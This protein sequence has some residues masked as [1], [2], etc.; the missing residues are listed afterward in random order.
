MA[1]FDHRQRKNTHKNEKRM[2]NYVG[3]R[4][5]HEKSHY[6]G[7]EWVLIIF[8]LCL[9]WIYIGIAFTHK[10]SVIVMVMTVDVCERK[11]EGVS[12]SFFYTLL[13]VSLHCWVCMCAHIACNKCQTSRHAHHRHIVCEQPCVFTVNLTNRYHES[14]IFHRKIRI[15]IVNF[16]VFATQSM[17]SFQFLAEPSL[18]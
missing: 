7:I 17:R 14:N 1:P 9:V 5:F 6:F 18:F 2:W 3:A 13:R 10:Y 11:R 16:K 4:K 12:H 8:F 15:C